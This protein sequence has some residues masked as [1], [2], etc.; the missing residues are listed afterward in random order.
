MAVRLKPAGEQVA[1]VVGASSGIGRETALR[2]AGRG[3]KVV[4]AARGE[5]GLRSLVREIEARG[6]QTEDGDPDRPSRTL[7]RPTGATAEGWPLCSRAASPSALTRPAP[8]RRWRK[9]ARPC[10]IGSPAPRSAPWK[11][12]SSP[13]TRLGSA[14]SGCGASESPWRSIPCPRPS[15]SVRRRGGDVAA[16]PRPGERSARLSRAARDAS[17]RQRL[18]EAAKPCGTPRRSSMAKPRTKDT[19][20]PQAA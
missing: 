1:V 9:R 15:G 11:P 19:P 20:A 18:S 5:P 6:G 8:T 3:A 2:F 10:P 13:A 16:G 14:P 12:P 17:A 4:V 7:R